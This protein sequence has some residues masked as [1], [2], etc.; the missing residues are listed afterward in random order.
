MRTFVVLI[1]ER[2]IS[3]ASQRLC[4]SQSAVSEQ[5][6]KLES[7][8][9]VSLAVRHR[10]GV[11]PTAAGERLLAHAR[12]MLALSDLACRDV[13]AVE[14]DEEIHL[15]ITDYF[16]PAAIAPLLARIQALLP[17]LR[18]RISIVDSASIRSA[19]SGFDIGVTMQ[20]CDAP[21]PGT[22]GAD[23]GDE[24]RL[25]QESLAWVASPMYETTGAAPLPLVLLDDACHLH[26]HVTD[27]LS[28]AGIAYTMRHQ[29]TG[30]AGIQ[31]AVAAGLG[32]TCLN[33]S[34]M[35]ADMIDVT[36][37][38]ALPPM[39]DVAFVLQPV[40]RGESRAVAA[41]RT[42]LQQFFQ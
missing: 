14:I 7:Q 34:A 18:L 29:A 15:G 33:R 8:L 24:I 6:A 9:G 42:V 31:A 1:G 25:R 12:E 37:R 32:I 4:C 16:R 11:V 27:R 39:P 41:L 10:R 28:A 20:L 30:V 26:R 13:A 5:L 38:L 23:T 3:R 2:N 22:D 36:S 17:A 35:T 21:E 19:D 40:R